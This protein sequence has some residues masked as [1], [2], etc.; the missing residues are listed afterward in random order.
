M[1]TATED[2]KKHYLDPR[3]KNIISKN[4]V[5]SNGWRALNGDFSTWYKYIDAD[6]RLLNFAE[7]YEY[8]AENF[9]TL[10]STLNVFDTGLMKVV[11]KKNGVT[12]ETPLGT[13]EETTAYTLGTD[14]DKGH[15]YEIEDPLVKKA[16]EDAATFL[17]K[18]LSDHGVHDSVWVLFSGGGIYVEVHHEICRSIGDRDVFFEMVTDRFNRML[19]KV[20]D[21]FFAVHPEHTGKVKFDALNNS[22]RVFK[23]IFSIHKKKPY[24]VI[25]LN[26]ADIRIDFE[27]ARVPLRD[28]VIEDAE[29]WYGTY[30]IEERESLLKL[31]NKF[32]PSKTRKRT[33]FN[34][35][36]RAPE[37][38]DEKKFCPCIQHILNNENTGEGR[39]R[40]TGILSAFLYSMG[41]DE[42]RAFK[43]VKEISER[44]GVGQ[45]EHIFDS[46][47]GK[48]SCPSCNKIQTDSAG[49]PH[50]GL[51]GLNACNP[52]Q[53]CNSCRWPGEY[54][55]GRRRSDIPIRGIS[56]SDNFGAVGVADDGTVRMVDE[57]DTQAGPK[58]FLKWVSDC[59]VWVD[60]ETRADSKTE[61]TF[62]GIGANDKTRKRFTLIANDLAEPRKFRGALINAFGG[63]NKVG[64]LEF[65]TVQSLTRYIH[66]MKRVEIPI[67][68]S[69]VPLVPGVDL[70][71]DVEYRLSQMTPASVYDGN[72]EE[73]LQILIKYMNLHKYSPLL[74]TTILGSPAYARWHVNDRF[75]LGLWGPSGTQKTT[76]LQLGMSVYGIGYLEDSALLKHGKVGSTLVAALEVF[77][78]SGILPQMLDNVKTVVEKDAEQYISLVH[79]VL[80]GREKLRGKKEMSGLRIARAFQCTPIITGEVKPDEASTSARVL[81]VPWMTKASDQEL[82]TEVQ[83]N[84]MLMPVIGYNWLR[85]LADT[86]LNLVDGFDAARDKKVGEY[87]SQGFVN[88]GRLAT[89]YTLLRS[90][91]GLLLESPLSDAFSEFDFI[92]VLDEIIIEQGIMVTGET[93]SERFLE[94]LEQLLASNPG[95][96]VSEEGNR[97]YGKCMGKNLDGNLFLL[98]DVVLSE[99]NRM[100]IFV[101]KP[102]T[103]SLARDLIQKGILL[104]SG[105]GKYS[106]QERL[107]G[108][109]VRGWLLSHLDETPC[110]NPGETR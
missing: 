88:P 71:P 9:R 97:L 93:E 92:K 8:V 16:V 47:Y 67:W 78:G 103:K 49:Y 41:W 105:D 35:I 62:E 28:E 46:C 26:R 96:I 91:W 76:M 17:V 55:V 3:I 56:P 48:I 43:K 102:S 31:L 60:T 58:K 39:T 45:F 86:T 11:R 20:S 36:Y 80:E 53:T 33:S 108:V 2:T 23:S 66:K 6:V 34:E 99:L 15:G 104:K 70:L 54:S 85:F 24:A 57:I 1:K 7:D 4:T 100:G 84:V 30:K 83:R 106:R 50:L 5:F 25:P 63:A 107:N 81:N 72:L 61:L 75:G 74:I 51:K 42:E 79:A 90:T 44:N 94:G 109:R 73:A 12:S 27:R 59:A 101:Q 69:N 110:H 65:E 32:S 37:V 77:A 38:V 29:F 64:K 18:F 82:L 21:E 89:I 19:G 95:M 10:Y 52:D 68:S 87:S 22:K 98:P 40:F 13:P 14:I